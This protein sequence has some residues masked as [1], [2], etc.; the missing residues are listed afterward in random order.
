[1]D[2]EEPLPEWAASRSDGDYMVP[3]TQLCTRDG[4]RMGNAVVLRIEPSAHV[5]A[6]SL[7]VVQTD[8]GNNMKMTRGELEE[9]FHPPIFILKS[10]L[11]HE[12]IHVLRQWKCDSCG[13]KGTYLN[14]NRITGV[15]TIPCKICD[16]TG[17]HTRARMAIA[18]IEGRI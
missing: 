13:G 18:E 17:I 10:A 1:M 4:R 2:I 14:K 7:A 16:G 12:R 3:M 11:A 15:S 6:T 5:L 9:A 8:A